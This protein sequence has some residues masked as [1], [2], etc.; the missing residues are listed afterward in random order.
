MRALLFAALLAAGTAQAHKPSDS[1]LTL[2]ADGRSLRGQW[3]IALRD[4]E[5][6][7]GLDANGD[8]SIT[9]GELSKRY[10]GERTK[11]K[12]AQRSDEPGT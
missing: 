4:L 11:A 3:D 5:F 9:W 6:A 7:I 8:G 1:Y 2:F 12:R 10:R